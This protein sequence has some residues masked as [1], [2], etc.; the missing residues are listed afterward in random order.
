MQFGALRL[1][2]YFFVECNQILFHVKHFLK[3]GDGSLYAT[4]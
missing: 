1:V 2:V 3:E 4:I